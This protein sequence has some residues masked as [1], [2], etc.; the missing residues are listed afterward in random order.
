MIATPDKNAVT[1]GGEVTHA[2]VEAADLQHLFD[3]LRKRGYE[4]YGPTVHEG[5]IVYDRIHAVADL[6]SGWTDEQAPGHYRLVRRADDALYK[7]KKAG[8][9]C[10]HWT[11]GENFFP[12][13]APASIAANNAVAEN[14]VPAAPAETVDSSST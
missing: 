1:Q 2:V 13:T 3:A 14:A 8:R 4:L 9:N 10:G 7:S 12:I 5:A 6:P 11:D